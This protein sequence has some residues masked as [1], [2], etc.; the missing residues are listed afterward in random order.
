MLFQK[1]SVTTFLALGQSTKTYSDSID[2]GR[3]RCKTSDKC[4]TRRRI[5]ITEL[6]V[7]VNWSNWG[8]RAVRY[9]IHL[10]LHEFDHN[11][12][13]QSQN[14]PFYSR[15]CRLEAVLRS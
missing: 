5:R 12:S 1:R 2:Q 4:T 3:P 13:P 8:D 7:V 6:G 14:V 15:I 9:I 10:S 11:S